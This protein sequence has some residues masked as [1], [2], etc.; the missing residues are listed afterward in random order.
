MLSRETLAPYVAARIVQEMQET[1]GRIKSLSPRPP[2]P[3]VLSM[4]LYYLTENGMREVPESEW[5]LTPEVVPLP[6]MELPQTERQER[7]LYRESFR[8][9]IVEPLAK[10]MHR[11]RCATP[12]LDE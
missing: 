12:P 2:R 5:R 7:E 9:R 11:G 3:P 1:W 10:R 6:S 4:S 8:R